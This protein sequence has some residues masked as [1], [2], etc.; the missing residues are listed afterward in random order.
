LANE[1]DTADITS[2][3]VPASF[4][5]W[6]TYIPNLKDFV[7][8]QGALYMN[9][10]NIQKIFCRKVDLRLYTKLFIILQSVSRETTVV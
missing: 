8:F 10:W 6:Y 7:Y 2:G 1:G 5:S 9:F 3:M 4:A